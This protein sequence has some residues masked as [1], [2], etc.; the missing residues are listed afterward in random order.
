ME[1]ESGILSFPVSTPSFPSIATVA[2]NVSK[3]SLPERYAFPSDREFRERVK[4]SLFPGARILD[5]GSGRHPT[6]PLEDRPRDCHYVG[7]DVSLDELERAPAGSYDATVTADVTERR[8]ELDGTF[9]LIISFQVLEHVKPLDEALDNLR[10]YLRPGGRMIAQMSGSFALFALAGRV[11][12]VRLRAWLLVALGRDPENIFPLHFHK[13]WQ[14]A[15]EK[16]LSS[17]TTSEVVPVHSGADY[18]RFSRFL[19][20]AYVGYEEW[21]VRNGHDNLA[22]YYL[23]DATR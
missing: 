1:S 16:I 9:D 20:S 6:V 23:V 22:S 7:L 2:R 13:C 17:W 5:V 12:P 11:V 15:L 19:Q 10:S 18:F 3:G 14:R 21:A 8:P 4:G